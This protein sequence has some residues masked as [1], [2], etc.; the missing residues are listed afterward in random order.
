MRTIQHPPSGCHG[1]HIT[2]EWG[3]AGIATRGGHLA[4]LPD[5]ELAD[6]SRPRMVGVERSTTHVGVVSEDNQLGSGAVDFIS[7]EGHV[8]E[9]NPLLKPFL[10]RRWSQFV[11]SF[12]EILELFGRHLVS[13][14]VELLPEFGG[15]PAYSLSSRID[16]FAQHHP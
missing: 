7:V 14:S 5:L 4:D 2:V 10:V 6:V 9:A 11:S 13:L 1:F 12:L 8:L 3:A 15:H 16:S